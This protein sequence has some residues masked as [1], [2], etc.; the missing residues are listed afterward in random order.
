MEHFPAMSE[1]ALKQSAA[2]KKVIA[3][4][5]VSALTSDQQLMNLIWRSK[6]ALSNSP[7]YFKNF[8]EQNSLAEEIKTNVEFHASMTCIHRIMDRPNK[9]GVSPDKQYLTK[10]QKRRLSASE[11]A[12]EVKEKFPELGDYLGKLMQVRRETIV[13]ECNE[14]KQKAEKNFSDITK[15]KSAVNEIAKPDLENKSA[16]YQSFTQSMSDAEWE[17]NNSKANVPYWQR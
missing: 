16:V 17:E 12:D 15:T 14:R 10:D 2:F 6:E 9:G 8:F 11:Y 3:D 13:Q 5:A 7:T 4:P 1:D